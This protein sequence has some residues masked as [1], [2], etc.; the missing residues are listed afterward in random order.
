[1]KNTTEERLEQLLDAC[2]RLPILIDSLEALLEVREDST[3]NERL[4]EMI[5]IMTQISGQFG[6]LPQLLEPVMRLD[7]RLEKLEDQMG[8]MLRFQKDLNDFLSSGLNE[9]AEDG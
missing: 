9:G 5:A 7:P 1:M 8:Q 3:L 6:E 4:L 2:Q